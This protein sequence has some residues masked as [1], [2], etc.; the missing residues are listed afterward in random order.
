[1]RE[2]VFTLEYEPGC[3]AVADTLAEFPDARIRSLSLHVT[4]GSLWRVDHATGTPGALAAIEETFLTADYYADCLATEDCGASQ[5]T[6][7]LEHTDET[8][9]LYSYWKRTPTCASVPHIAL[10]HLGDGAVLETRHEEREYRWRI[11]HPVA[12]DVRAF[13]EE[14]Q[15]VVEGCATM[16]LN[17]LTDA[18]APRA[19]GDDDLP[20]EQEEALR[21]AVEHGYYETPRAV[22]LGELA[23]TLDLPRSTLAYRL[24]RAEAHLAERRVARNRSSGS[25]L[26]SL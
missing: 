18:S 24:R 21:A 13:V 2:F 1:M 8:L 14:L 5:T 26:A 7:V 11:I 25:V 9:V 19:G 16:E 15:T 10:E 20:A 3:N 12:G 23:E 17:R 4:E 22:D 6:N